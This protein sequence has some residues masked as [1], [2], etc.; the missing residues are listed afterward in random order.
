MEFSYINTHKNGH[1]SIF[2]ILDAYDLTKIVL[3]GYRK[4][5]FK[6]GSVKGVLSPLL[7]NIII[8]SLAR[9]ICI[10]DNIHGILTPTT[11][12]KQLLYAVDTGFFVQIPVPVLNKVLHV[13]AL[14]SE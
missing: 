13:Y 14:V 10:Y 5:L 11:E 6:E 1:G 8:E 9:V 3:E 4:F 12:H 7:L 2:L